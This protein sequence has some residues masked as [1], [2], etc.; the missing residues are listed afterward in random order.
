LGVVFLNE[1][2]TLV[3]YLG[4]GVVLVGVYLVQSCKKQAQS[5]TPAMN[6]HAA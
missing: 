1:K 3:Q 4:V 6:K 5:A 2:I